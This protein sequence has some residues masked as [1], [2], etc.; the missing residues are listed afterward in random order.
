MSEDLHDR[1]PALWADPARPSPLRPLLMP[2]SLLYAAGAR[3][4]DVAWSREWRSAVRSALPTISVGNLSVG[5]TG[6]TPVASWVARWILDRQLVP[7]IVLRGYGDDEPEVHRRLVPEAIIVA[8]ADRVRGIA[9]ASVQGAQIA[10]LDDGFQHRRAVRDLDIVLLSAEQVERETDAQGCW[11]PRLL[12]AGPYREPVAALRR[13]QLIGLTRKQA[14]PTQAAR[15]AE[16]VRR[17][18]DVTPL[19]SIALMPDRLAA[20][21]GA[22][23]D[24]LGVAGRRVLAIA[25]IGA[26][27]LFAAQL[28]RL[29]ATV[30]LVAFADHY[31]FTTSDAARLA[32]KARDFDMAICTLKDAVKLMPLWPSEATPLSYLTQRCLI[33]SGAAQL[34]DLLEAVVARI[35]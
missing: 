21:D 10:V 33:E 30:T 22:T 29:G 1:L 6:K 26:P 19:L 9:T 13:A 25:G 35:T 32:V 11:R 31:P 27:A 17:E 18:I 15:A 34:H 4:V 5:G 2:L 3:A 28:E 16:A 8:D 20:A 7:A 12:P 23:T 24:A 14:S